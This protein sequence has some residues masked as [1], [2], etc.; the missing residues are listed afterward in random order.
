MSLTP[1]RQRRRT[2][3]AGLALLSL[4]ALA[5]AARADD[6]H[7]PAAA[8]VSYPHLPAHETVLDLVCRLLLDTNNTNS[9][10]AARPP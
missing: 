2:A 7:R 8:P 3:G 5:P 1:R 6:D 10:N 4:L 9:P